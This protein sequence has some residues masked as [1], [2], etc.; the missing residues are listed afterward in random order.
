MERDKQ[1]ERAGNHELPPVSVVRR[2]L[3]PEFEAAFLTRHPSSA[4]SQVGGDAMR[5][6]VA[7]WM[8]LVARCIYQQHHRRTAATAST[9]GNGL[10]RRSMYDTDVLIVILPSNF[11]PF[12][13][14]ATNSCC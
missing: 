14:P 3:Q 8:Q 4:S 6:V 5:L 10:H 1:R 12:L 9:T 2:P 13:A 11:V 7:A